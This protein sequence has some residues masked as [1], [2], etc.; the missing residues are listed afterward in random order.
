MK[1]SSSY[2]YI[3]TLLYSLYNIGKISRGSP[4]RSSLPLITES[5]AVLTKEGKA[6]NYS[7]IKLRERLGGGI[8]RRTGLKIPRGL[9]PVPVQVRP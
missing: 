7:S 8:G 3:L 9:P 5:Q 6:Y 2:I 1:G 4:L